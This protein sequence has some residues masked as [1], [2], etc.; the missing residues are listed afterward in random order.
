MLDILGIAEEP[1]ILLCML[2]LD[3]AVGVVIL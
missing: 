3:G 1:V 2:L